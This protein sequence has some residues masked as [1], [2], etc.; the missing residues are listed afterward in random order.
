MDTIC[1]QRLLL[2]L[3]ISICGLFSVHFGS[4]FNLVV[5]IIL[6]SIIY[7]Q[8]DYVDSLEAATIIRLMKAYYDS[9]LNDPDEALNILEQINQLI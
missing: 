8:L 3:N 1:H 2:P 5:N 7:I 6:M 9:L 4:F